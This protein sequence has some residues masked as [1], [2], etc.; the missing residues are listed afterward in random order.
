AHWLTARLGPVVLRGPR[1][2]RAERTETADGLVLAARHDGY[3]AEF[4][5]VHER[6]WSLA[7]DGARL[8]GEDAFLR[9]PGRESGRTRPRDVAVRFH[10]H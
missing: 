3:A 2:V 1:A 6:R 5:L 7:A 9:A 8:A 10:L 4:G